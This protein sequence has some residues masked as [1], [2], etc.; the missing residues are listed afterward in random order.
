M[1]RDRGTRSA[2]RRERASAS[3]GQLPWRPLENPYEPVEVLTAE[4]IEAIH[5]ASLTVLRD[6]GMDFL[7]PEALDILRSGGADVADDG[8]RVRFD[9]ALIEELIST[10]PA[11][12]EMYA[13][14]PE[15]NVTI[16]GRHVNF[17]SVGSAPNSSSLDSGR[18]A[19]TFAD[20]SDLVKLTQYFN[21]VSIHAGYPVEPVDIDPSIRHLVALAEIVRQSD[22]IF[23][24]YSLG[25]ERILDAL[26]I[27]RISRGVSMEQ[28]MGEPS[29]H[30]IVNTSSPLR[31]D[32]PM[33]EGMIEMLRHGQVVVITPFTL[34]GAMAPATIA[35]AL[36]QQNAEALAGMAFS[37]LVEPGSKIV[38]GG[39]TS[40]VDM[41]SGSPAFGTPEYTRAAMAGGQ[42]ARRYGVPYRSSNATAAN[43]VDQR[44]DH[45]Q[46]G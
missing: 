4:Q 37:Q 31:L 22:K 17:L 32:G 33:I 30:T 36:V 41:R 10:I 27:V 34:S 5:A 35:G 19:G 42:L 46:S 3:I 9:P 23:H 26:E 45:H 13:R 21:V 20:F 8:P 6:T 39:F 16:G 2:R 44:G 15:R 38:Y 18:R 14:N 40:N 25:R 43:A 28:L 29:L 7:H 12:F 1:A 11:Q 24:G